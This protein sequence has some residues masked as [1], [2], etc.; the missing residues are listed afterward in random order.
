MHR[1]SGIRFRDGMREYRRAKENE[2]QMSKYPPE[3][4]AIKSKV[5]DLEAICREYEKNIEKATKE[6]EREHYERDL[7]E[8]RN[9]IDG[10]RSEV[11]QSYGIDI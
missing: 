1:T 8:Q 9:K 4:Y 2:S 7:K 3:V 6:S 10:L 5:A 11:K